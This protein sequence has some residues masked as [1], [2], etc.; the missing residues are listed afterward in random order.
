MA[1]PC[2]APTTLTSASGSTPPSRPLS[3]APSSQSDLDQLVRPHE[4]TAR[5]GLAR[6]LP[7]AADAYFRA[8]RVSGA[9]PPTPAP[10]VDAGFAVVLVTRGAGRLVAT[11][12]DALDV[13]RG[14]VAVVPWA[15]GTWRL[16]GD[17]EAVVCRPP[18]PANTGTAS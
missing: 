14:N 3:S 11:S 17:V 15:A 12:G 13:T 7:G 4:R 18:L 16:E 2:P 5:A 8:H 6:L 10:V 1:S 9:P